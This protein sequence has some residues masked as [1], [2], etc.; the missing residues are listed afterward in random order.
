MEYPH[1]KI[2]IHFICYINSLFILNIKFQVFD[3]PFYYYIHY[4]IEVLLIYNYYYMFIFIYNLDVLD[5]ILLHILYLSLHLHNI[6][7]MPHKIFY[8]HLHCYT[9]IPYDHPFI[10]SL[11]L[12]LSIIM[13]IMLNH[14]HSTKHLF[15]YW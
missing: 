12:Q 6:F 1:E 14:F 3:M 10:L 8:L 9:T 2:G 7:D 15:S 4:Y 11:N 13:H 5:H